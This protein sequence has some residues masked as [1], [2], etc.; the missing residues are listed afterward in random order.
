MPGE[1]DQPGRRRIRLAQ[2]QALHIR[3]TFS[4]PMKLVNCNGRLFGGGAAGGAGISAVAEAAR[5]TPPSSSRRAAH[6]SS[7]PVQRRHQPRLQKGAI[8][9]ALALLQPADLRL[10]VAHGDGQ[11]ALREAGAAAQYF[12]NAP[13]VP[14]CFRGYGG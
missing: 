11:L 4:R 5:A 9:L 12:S 10:A 8:R 13:N 2:Q 6:P 3:S 7:F 1:R 14:N